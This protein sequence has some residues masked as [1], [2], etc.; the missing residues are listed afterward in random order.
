M[1]TKEVASS[2][3][4]LFVMQHHLKHHFQDLVMDVQLKTDK[5]M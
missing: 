4:I 3:Y 2:V 5:S 1:L